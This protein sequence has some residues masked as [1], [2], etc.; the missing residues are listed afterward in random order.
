[1]NNSYDKLLNYNLVILNNTQ[2]I[3]YYA[4][5]QISTL[6]SSL[7]ID[8]EEKQQLVVTTN[9]KL[10][11][12]IQQTIDIVEKE[13]IKK[14]LEIMMESNQDIR[15]AMNIVIDYLKKQQ[16]KLAISK[17]SSA[18]A[19]LSQNLT[20]NANHI[21]EHQVILLDQG[22]KDNKKRADLMLI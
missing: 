17:A 2:A 7:I 12:L 19:V 6:Y 4:T 10:T 18:L 13:D 22:S 1:M 16:V 8:S 14:D 11:D 15:K 20:D 3:K 21:A 5:L 9:Q